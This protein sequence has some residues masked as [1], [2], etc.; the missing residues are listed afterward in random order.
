M[1]DLFYV[2][3]DVDKKVYKNVKKTSDFLIKKENKNEVV[4]TLNNIQF[5][6]FIDNICIREI[7]NW[8]NDKIKKSNLYWRIILASN[9]EVIIKEGNNFEFQK[10]NN[11][12]FWVNKMKLIDK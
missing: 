10:F 2:Q 4:I 12:C 6:Q 8:K 7:I 5:N 1:K 11:I 9:Y 3:V